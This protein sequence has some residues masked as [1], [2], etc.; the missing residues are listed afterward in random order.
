MTTLSDIEIAQSCHPKHLPEIA[1]RRQGAFFDDFLF[2]PA[3]AT[4][5]ELYTA[6]FLL[7]RHRMTRCRFNAAIFPFPGQSDYS[8]AKIALPF[9]FNQ[10]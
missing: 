2:A 9:F 8:A 10:R 6:P 5:K 4:K 3:F 7:F 1:G